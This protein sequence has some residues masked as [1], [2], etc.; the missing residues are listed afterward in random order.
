LHRAA[1][2]GFRPIPR[3]LGDQRWRHDPTDIA[4]FRQIAIQPLSTWASFVDKDEVFGLRLKFPDEVIEVTL[5]GPNGAKK[6]DLGTVIVG[7]ICHGNRIFVDI[8]TDGQRG[9]LCHG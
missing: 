6:D 3:F 9:R 1:T 8:Q 5:A 2:V 7:D 4:F